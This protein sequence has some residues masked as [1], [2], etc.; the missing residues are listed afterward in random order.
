MTISELRNIY[1][2]SSTKASDINRKLIFA[3]I[4]IVWI[5]RDATKLSIDKVNNIEDIAACAEVL[6]PEPFKPILL[7]YCISLCLDV[8]QY[9][10]R[11]MVWHIYYHIHR[12]PEEEEKTIQAKEPEWLNALPDSFWYAKFVPTLFAY[13]KLAGLLSITPFGKW[14][15]LQHLGGWSMVYTWAIVL[16]V[17]LV[18]YAFLEWLP[19]K[20]QKTSKICSC[21]RFSVGLVLI[22]IFLIKLYLGLTI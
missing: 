7:L 6:I 9:V 8:M 19:I 22:A 16:G 13:L 21:T 15:W 3:G 2:G 14:E 20:V 5:F 18:W 10:V 4:A 1:E 17:L 11:A 12:V